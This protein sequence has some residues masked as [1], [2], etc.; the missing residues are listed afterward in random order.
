M[1]RPITLLRSFVHHGGGTYTLL[2]VAENSE[3]RDQQMAVYVSHHRG[4]VLVR[5]WAMFNEE[6]TWPD[7]VRRPRFAPIPFEEVSEP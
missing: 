2:Y 3:D 7:G 4:K 5:P 6:V 1:T